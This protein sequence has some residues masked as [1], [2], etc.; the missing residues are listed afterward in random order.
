MKN[1]V[2]PDGAGFVLSLE[3]TRYS[4]NGPTNILI[5][6]LLELDGWIPDTPYTR[7]PEDRITYFTN[8]TYNS[9]RLGF[10]KRYDYY[11]LD[12]SPATL[13][14]ILCTM[15]S[16]LR[17]NKLLLWHMRFAHQNIEAM[18]KMVQLQMVD[19]MDLSS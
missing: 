1:V 7:D 4:P 12:A 11:W 8:D 17:E 6:E 19:G 3:D 10:K 14:D 18:R 13:Q 5:Q 9:V 2:D 15:L 16:S